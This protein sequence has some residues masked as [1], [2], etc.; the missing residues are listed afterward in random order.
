MKEELE[1]LGFVS[2]KR[3]LCS[4]VKIN[5]TIRSVK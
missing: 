5:V 2:L 4:V 3:V 1:E